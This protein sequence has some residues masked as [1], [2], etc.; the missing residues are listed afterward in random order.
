MPQKS[1][2]PIQNRILA[3]LPAQEYQRLAKHLTPVSL[4]LGD[5]IYQTDE[6]ITCVYFVHTGV[7]SLVANLKEHRWVRQPAPWSD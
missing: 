1:Q 6:P 5:S 2:A 4:D 3:A 7:I